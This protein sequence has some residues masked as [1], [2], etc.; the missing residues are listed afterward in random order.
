MHVTITVTYDLPFTV[1]HWSCLHV[2]VT[3]TSL[4]LGEVTLRTITLLK[5]EA[6]LV[7]STNYKIE[8]KFYPVLS[9]TLYWLNC[10]SWS[11]LPVSINEVAI[12]LPVGLQDN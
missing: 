3:S 8:G 6:V 11:C 12:L 9:S 5:G 10:N 2:P 4:L 7:K 1:Q